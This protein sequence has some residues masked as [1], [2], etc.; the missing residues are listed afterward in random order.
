MPDQERLLRFTILCYRNPTMTEDEFHKHWTTRHGPL[1]KEWL[2][3]HG[4]LKYTQVQNAPFLFLHM[5]PLQSKTLSLLTKL[6]SHTSTIP[7]NSFVSAHS[8]FPVT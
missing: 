6:A 8:L 5:P 7:P 4:V 2:A 1:V 3:R